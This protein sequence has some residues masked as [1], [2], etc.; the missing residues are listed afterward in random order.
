MSWF[1]IKHFLHDC[2][3][4]PI[5]WYQRARYGY[6]QRDVND[7]CYH[8]CTI[9]PNMARELRLRKFSHPAELTWEQWE[10]TLKDIE[11]AFRLV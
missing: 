10:E 4:N 8:L 7:M 3:Y 11:N 1:R 9:I 6:S 5:H 2:Y